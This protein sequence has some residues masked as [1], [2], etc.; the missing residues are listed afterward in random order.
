[1]KK[2]EK[3]CEIFEKLLRTGKNSR[4]LRGEIFAGFL[5]M[6]RAWHNVMPRGGHANK[7]TA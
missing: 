5:A 2:Q 1:V 6:G 4:S 3:A 7:N